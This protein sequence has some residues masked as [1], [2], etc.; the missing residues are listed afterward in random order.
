MKKTG[1]Y[2]TS[3]L[4]EAQFEPGSRRRVLKN[5]L[6]I[7]RKR[8]MDLVETEALKR[9]VDKLVRIYD[10]N[11]R[12]TEADLRKMHEIWLGKIYEW[13]G[14]Y[15]QVNISKGNFTFAA[16]NRVPLLMTEFEKGTLRKHTPCNFKLLKRITQAL[17]EVHTEFLL[18]HPF[19]EGNG[20][21]ARVLATIMASQTG[22]PLLDFGSIKGK[23]REEYFSAVRA[24]LDRNYR[25][26]EDIFSDVIQQTLKSY[27]R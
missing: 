15:R 27:K 25:P 19:R 1:R 21:I 22:L 14:D 20:R 3:D 24:G 10:Q 23:R 16:A 7:S 5:R 11:H 4:I 17:A 12:F 13:A 2:D 6:G 18:I 26:M 9:T 8:E